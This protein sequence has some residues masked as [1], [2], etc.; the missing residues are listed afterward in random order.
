MFDANNEVDIVKLQQQV[1]SSD[2]S[3]YRIE[4]LTPAEFNFAVKLS[5]IQFQPQMLTATNA[6]EFLK[7]AA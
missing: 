1:D 6:N 2:D 3:K 7:V 4:L 5:S